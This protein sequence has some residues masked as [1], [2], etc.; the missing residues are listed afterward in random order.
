MKNQ[1][2][3]F[4][5]I[6]IILFCVSCEANADDKFDILSKDNLVAWC[7]V[8]FDAAKRTPEQRA[9]MLSQL[10][11]KRCAYDW[12]AEHVPTFEQ[13]I[14]AYKKGGIEF[15]A[16]WSIHEE[17]F[18]LFEKHDLHP[19]IWYMMPQPIS[20]LSPADSI[21]HTVAKM[22]PVVERTKAAGCQLGLYNHGGWAGQPENLVAVCNKFH[23]LGHSHLGIVYNFHHAHDRIEDWPATFNKLKPY[24]LC[25]NING[26]NDGAQPKI[27][28][29]G[30][31]QHETAMLKVVVESDYQ[32]PIGILDHRNER[33]AKDSLLENMNGLEAIRT[34]IKE[35]NQK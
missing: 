30:R 16:F 25:L 14:L 23:Q 22:M 9:A 7:I 24:L 10:G 28:S 11:I 18:Q 5:G 32:G 27:L 6:F 12:R 19:Q 17:A 8:P 3:K 1:T 2:L 35:S 34:Q 13:E 26:M 21:K 20:G 29:L 15:F 33:D 31:G 4:I